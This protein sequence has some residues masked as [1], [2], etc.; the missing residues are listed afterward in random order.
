MIDQNNHMKL[1]KQNKKHKTKNY[2]YNNEHNTEYEHVNIKKLFKYN[3]HK[4]K[5]NKYLYISKLVKC[6]NKEVALHAFSLLM[7][8]LMHKSPYYLK[9]TN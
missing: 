2:K 5:K 4:K 7:S 8:F 3:N 6:E 9:T 1:W